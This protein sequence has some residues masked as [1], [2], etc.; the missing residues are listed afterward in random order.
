MNK[1]IYYIQK[2]IILLIII[3]GCTKILI[4][5]SDSDHTIEDFETAWNAINNVY[6]LLEYKGLDWDSI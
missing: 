1:K 6:P 4:Q 2:I 5:P 3:Q